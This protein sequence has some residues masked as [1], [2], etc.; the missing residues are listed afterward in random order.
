[1]RNIFKIAVSALAVTAMTSTAAVNFPFPQ[2]MKSPNGYTIP[3]ADTKVIQD[4]FNQWKKAW[5]QDKDTEA[6]ILAPEGDCSTVSEAI[7][8]G[9]MI[10]VYMSDSQNDH[11]T[12][13]DKLYA[14][15]KNHGGNGGG[16]DWRIGC[17]G[18]T[19]SATDADVDAALALVMASKQWGVSSY[20]DD[21]KKIISWMATNDVNDGHLKPGNAWNDYFNP[22]YGALANLELFKSV[23]GGSWGTVL[24][25]TEQDLLKCQ[26]ATSGLVTDWCTWG[27][28]QP[29]VNGKA[30][31]SQNE[32]AGFYDDAARTPWRT[33]WAYYW[34]GNANAKKF[35]E[36]ITKW[37]YTATHTASGIIAGYLPDGTPSSS[38]NR[39][40][41]SSTFYGG[42]GLAASSFEDKTSKTYMETVYNALA[43]KVSC[44]QAANCGTGNNAGEK[45]Y[46]ATLNLL[47]LLLM[48]GNM[49]NF[50][51]M[52]GF[53]KF[54]PDPSLATS[55][56]VVEGQQMEKG[57]TTVGISG[58]WNWG[59][60]HDRYDIGTKMSPDSGSSPLFMKNGSIV[61]EA[62]MEIGP[63]P[64]WTQ[65]AA[66]A[67]TLKYPSAGIAM[68][69]LKSEKGVDLT[70]LGVKAIRLN[71]KSQGPMRFA[72]LNTSAPEPGT[73][74]G[75]YIPAAEDFTSFSFNLKINSSGSD[76]DE[77]SLDGLVYLK[78]IVDGNKTVEESKVMQTASGVKFEVKAAKGGVG[79]IAIK[80]IEF[81]DASGN[82]VDPSKITGLVV[83]EVV[84][85]VDPVD[86]VDP[87]G[88][89]A[90][91]ALTMAKIS[92]SGMN[93]AVDG[94]KAGTDIAVFNM[95]GKVIA[96]GKATFGNASIAVPS[97]GL[98]VVRVGNKMSK[99]TVK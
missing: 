15:W 25:T 55:V 6:W 16:M 67:G 20:L 78:W 98:Y 48:T 63:E 94:A 1:M 38:E 30:A 79:S 91:P 46:P 57:D 92:V 86:P 35:N 32:P 3:F 44:S 7:A 76:N 13:F 80:G 22:S 14:T 12:E 28:Y 37:L 40:F 59:A 36:K 5:Y 39:Q 34:Y 54:T 73:E 84:G 49:P 19:G 60:Y 81:L 74:P 62:S 87:L 2:N 45:Y 68:S 56:T 26:N 58:F 4:H 52:S 11:K 43:K 77:C 27:S 9:M 97:K 82:V 83:P 64:E 71:Y 90:T 61:A 89:L 31:V 8:Y 66:A 10:M 41:G 23:S 65:E 50:Y 33:A 18:G 95:Q 88:V 29:T 69:F 17:S 21:A 47:Y 75:C 53:T 42:L 72:L 93:I 70:A 99:V 96:S 85:P 51:D 24:S